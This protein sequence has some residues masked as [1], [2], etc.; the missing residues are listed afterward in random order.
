MVFY[1]H[2]VAAKLATYSRRSYQLYIIKVC[3]PVP[4]L[5]GCAKDIISLAA[6]AAA[7]VHLMIFKQLS[8]IADVDV[9][10]VTSSKADTIN[11]PK[12]LQT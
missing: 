4:C 9:G 7:A 6:T 5:S 10:I 11:K 3:L 1:E 8:C 2:S 12:L